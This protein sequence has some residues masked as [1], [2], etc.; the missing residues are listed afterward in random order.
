MWHHELF[1]TRSL[2]THDAEWHM[3]LNKGDRISIQA[4]GKGTFGA[5]AI[6][7]ACTKAPYS[8]G[9]Q[10]INM[11]DVMPPVK[12]T[13]FLQ[14][15]CTTF[16]AIMYLGSNGRYNI[17]NKDTWYDAGST[18]DWTSFVDMTS[19]VHDKAKLPKKI[20]FEFAEMK[21][22]A[23]ENF[24]QSN[25]RAFGSMSFTPD[26]D[27]ADAPMEIKSPFSIVTPQLMNKV[28]SRYQTIGVTNMQ[29]QM[30]INSNLEPACSNM[31]LFYMKDNQVDSVSGDTYFA[32]G[33]SRSTYPYAGTYS[34]RIAD[35]GFSLAYSL[36]QNVDGLVVT[37]TLFSRYWSRHVARIFAQSA[38]KVTMTAYIPVGTWLNLELNETIRI[39][40]HYYKIDNIAY[41]ITTGKTQ[42]K[43]FTYV[44][45]TI[46]TITTNSDGEVTLP[47]DYVSPSIE[48]VI[49]NARSVA[50]L[51]NIIAIGSANYVQTG[52]PIR[53]VSTNQ[54]V[55]DMALQQSVNQVPIAIQMQKD[56][57][58][59]SVAQGSYTTLQAYDTEVADNSGYLTAD[60][61]DGTITA[62]NSGFVR[63][64]CAVAWDGNDKIKVAL[65]KNDDTILADQE[66]EGSEGSITLEALTYMA[67]T[68]TIVIGLQYVGSGENKTYSI[69]ADLDV[70]QE[71]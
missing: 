11:A 25:Q 7:W 38:R 43:L 31:V 8:R 40:D 63:V 14:G 69:E 65:I 34:K 32:A 12:L 2:T 58:S 29:V 17:V 16:N 24:L 19:V 42:I 60:T 36:E 6:T 1:D 56:E 70:R 53:K 54:I 33:S 50:D 44:P 3:Q 66:V 22:M 30:L 45:L 68:D 62:S 57:A 26:I 15:I 5:N 61:G 55:R 51:N 64:S 41:D 23:S 52:L 46:G 67:N 4:L 37:D 59:V 21:D 28:N 20:S 27:F 39:A 48:N 47:S 13:S 10:T 49:F 18:L 71:V 9:G 35:D